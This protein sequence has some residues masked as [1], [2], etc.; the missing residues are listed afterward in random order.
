MCKR[1]CSPIVMTVKKTIAR[2]KSPSKRGAKR[3]HQNTNYRDRVSARVPFQ[4]V[5]KAR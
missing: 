4:M 2:R 3:E 5:C 1:A